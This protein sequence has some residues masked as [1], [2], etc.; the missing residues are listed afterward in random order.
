MWWEFCYAGVSS[1]DSSLESTGV[2][3]FGTWIT[4]GL[5]SGKIA[6]ARSSVETLTFR[7]RSDVWGDDESFQKKK[8]S[9]TKKTLLTIPIVEVA[10]IACSSLRFIWLA[11]VLCWAVSAIVSVFIDVWPNDI[12]K[13]K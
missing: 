9:D 13:F 1:L 3:I 8:S 10:A 7:S 2:G 11:G 4:G 5:V 6:W 12:Y